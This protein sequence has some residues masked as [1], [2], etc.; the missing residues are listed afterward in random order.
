MSKANIGPLDG[1][2]GGKGSG[3]SS[4]LTNQGQDKLQE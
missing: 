3:S 2:Y 4:Q 1:S